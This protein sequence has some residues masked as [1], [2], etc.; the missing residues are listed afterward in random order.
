MKAISK[1]NLINKYK[2]EKIIDEIINKKKRT[3][4]I[5]NYF[6]EKG[7]EIEIIT[8]NPYSGMKVVIAENK[9]K[10]RFVINYDDIE[11]KK[12]RKFKF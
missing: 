7:D 5:I 8:Q 6:C 12:E 10:D 2:P 11:F 9:H 3:T 1:I 4:K